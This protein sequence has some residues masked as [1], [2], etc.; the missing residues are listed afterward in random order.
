MYSFLW[1]IGC[2]IGARFV[3]SHEL[4]E[5]H[6][7]HHGCWRQNLDPWREINNGCTLSRFDLGRIPMGQRMGLWQKRL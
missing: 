4:L 7:S 2:A 5:T 3:L 1:L 6:V